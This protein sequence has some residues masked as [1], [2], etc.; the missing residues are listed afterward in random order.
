MVENRAGDGRRRKGREGIQGGTGRRREG[1]KGRE[2]ERTDG[3]KGKGY[4]RM[5]R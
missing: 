2:K 1:G 4:V 3:E 5:L